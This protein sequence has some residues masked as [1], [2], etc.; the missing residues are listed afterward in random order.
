MIDEF[1]VAETVPIRWP[2]CYRVSLP[3]H[4][5]FREELPF[6]ET[7]REIVSYTDPVSRMSEGSLAPNYGVGGERTVDLPYPLASAFTTLDDSLFGDGG[8]GIL[9]LIPSFDGAVQE[10]CDRVA[11]LYAATGCDTATVDLVVTEFSLEGEFFDYASEPNSELIGPDSD[12]Q[13]LGRLLR[14]DVDRNADGMTFIAHMGGHELPAAAVFQANSISSVVS[15][16]LVR[17]VY[18]EGRFVGFNCLSPF[19]VFSSE[20][21]V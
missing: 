15:Q 2:Q 16:Q 6:S 20:I 12:R 3:I 8:F 5:G 13:E 1:A 18:K 19:R 4:S 10:F 21:G 9:Y 7:E 11:P 17:V 14:A